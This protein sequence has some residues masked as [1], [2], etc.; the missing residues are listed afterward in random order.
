MKKLIIFLLLCMATPSIADV[1]IIAVKISST[2]HY[3]SLV[4]TMMSENIDPYFSVTNG[5]VWIKQGPPNAEYYI[6]E[7]DVE[8][9]NFPFR[10]DNATAW[11]NSHSVDFDNPQNVIILKKFT[12]NWSPYIE[13]Q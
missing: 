2:L 3:M 13:E 5:V 6:A 7:Y 11:I 8:G 1:M 9:R 12:I 4:E 10:A